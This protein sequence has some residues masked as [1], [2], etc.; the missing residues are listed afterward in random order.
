MENDYREVDQAL[1]SLGMREWRTPSIEQITKK[2]FTM[3]KV[4]RKMSR[5][6]LALLI[7]GMAVIGT[8]AAFGAAY[9][10]GAFNAKIVSDDG[11]EFN[12][13]LT[14]TGDG[15]YEGS[16]TDGQRIMFVK[17]GSDAMATRKLQLA[18]PESGAASIM[19]DPENINRQLVVEK[20]PKNPDQQ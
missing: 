2:E 3:N 10:M 17:E 6:N 19:V 13:Q 4:R 9:S 1:E 8:G 15:V 20:N 16:T 5:T 14:E 12:G 18:S 11:R 7:G